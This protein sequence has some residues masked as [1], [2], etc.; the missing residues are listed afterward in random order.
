MSDLEGEVVVSKTNKRKKGVL[1]TESYKRNIIKMA[2]V[3]G[4]EHVNWT[5]RMIQAKKNLDQQ[6]AGKLLL[7]SDKN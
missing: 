7:Y 6:I 1:N 5:G 2:K 3:K 4:D